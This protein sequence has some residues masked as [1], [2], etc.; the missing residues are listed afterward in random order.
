MF[1]GIRD[2]GRGKTCSEKS[3]NIIRSAQVRDPLIYQQTF[4]PL[5]WHTGLLVHWHTGLLA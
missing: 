3:G 1:S 4:L 2:N 5:C